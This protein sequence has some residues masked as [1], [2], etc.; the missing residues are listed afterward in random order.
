[1]DS[2]GVCPTNY[3]LVP[4][5]QIVFKASAS[6]SSITL[7]NNIYWRDNYAPGPSDMRGKI[8]EITIMNGI[9]TMNMITVS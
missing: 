9:A 7:P 8:C 3:S 2:L 4:T 5:Y 6:F 1:M